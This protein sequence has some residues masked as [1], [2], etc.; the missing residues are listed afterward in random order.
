MFRATLPNETVVALI[1]RT[2]VARFSCTANVLAI[3]LTV[4][5]T[6]AV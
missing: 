4:D 5:V 2:C 6:V 3:P 1:V